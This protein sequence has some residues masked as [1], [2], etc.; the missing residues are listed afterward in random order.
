MSNADK[1]V[2]NGGFIL[3]GLALYICIVFPKIFENGFT[4][5][6]C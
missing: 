6:I 5:P 1:S 2:I 3:N 4:Y